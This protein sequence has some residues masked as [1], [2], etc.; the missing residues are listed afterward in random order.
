MDMYTEFVARYPQMENMVDDI[1][2][3]V[4][5]IVNC[6]RSGGKVLICGN[7]GSASDSCHIVGELMKGFLKKRPLTN[8]ER[9]AMREKNPEISDELIDNLQGSLPA[10][11]LTENS[12]II[13]A[14]ANDVDPANVYAQQVLGYGQYNDVLIGITTSGN[15][16]NVINAC[17]VA[18]ALGVNVIG[19]TGKD[20][21]KLKE[22]S[23][24]CLIAPENETFKIQECHLPIYHLI[25]AAVEAEFYNI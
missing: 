10:I 8:E 14:F 24:V 22:L 13:S 3:T 2:K 18:K 15:S 20:G 19:L 5:I 23:D 16:V 7:G 11:N 6:Y 1:K 9:S 25:C 21:G 4:D 17:H 12:G